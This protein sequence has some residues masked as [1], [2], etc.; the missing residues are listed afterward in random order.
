MK[1]KPDQSE[2]CGSESLRAII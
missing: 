1:S 2:L